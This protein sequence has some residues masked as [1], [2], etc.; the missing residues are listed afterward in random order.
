[1]F[2]ANIWFFGDAHSV[3]TKHENGSMQT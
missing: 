3:C 2:K 1:M